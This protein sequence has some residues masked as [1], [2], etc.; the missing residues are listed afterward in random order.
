MVFGGNKLTIGGPYSGL[1]RLNRLS[2]WRRRRGFRP[3]G[4]QRSVS[5]RP[6][7]VGQAPSEVTCLVKLAKRLTFSL[8]KRDTSGD[9][10]YL[11]QPER[12]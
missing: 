1:R 12:G 5:V 10:Q 6:Q 2:A 4:W 3:R 9:R 11:E 7:N 8:A